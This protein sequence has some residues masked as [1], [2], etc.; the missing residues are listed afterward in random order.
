MAVVV[1]PPDQARLAG[2]DQDV[3]V[4]P[5]VLHPFPDEHAAPALGNHPPVATLVVEVHP[6]VKGVGGACVRSRE[7]NSGGGGG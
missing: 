3:V 1:F 2:V 6:P 4:V 7:Q 5:L